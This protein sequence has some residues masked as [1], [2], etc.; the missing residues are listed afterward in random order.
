MSWLPI[1]T[2]LY[3]GLHKPG[4]IV[5]LRSISGMAVAAAKQVRQEAVVAQAEVLVGGTCV[6]TAADP[7]AWSGPRP[8]LWRVRALD[9]QTYARGVFP[10]DCDFLCLAF[11]EHAVSSR[12]RRSLMLMLS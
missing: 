7:R 5:F 12:Q 2:R 6:R 4:R 8:V 9:K 1:N 10:L 3:E 11:N